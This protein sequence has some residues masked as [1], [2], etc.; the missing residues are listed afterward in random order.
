[1]ISSLILLVL[2]AA[3]Y[4]DALVAVCAELFALADLGIL[5]AVAVYV[6]ARWWME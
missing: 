1:M 5:G 3:P 2:L 6:G 4:W